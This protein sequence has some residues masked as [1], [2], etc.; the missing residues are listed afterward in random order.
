MLDCAAICL[1]DD[2]YYLRY[3][4]EALSGVPAHVFV[5]RLNWLGESSKSW[6]PSMKAA[7]S[8]GAI[9]HIGD[10]ATEH[11]HRLAALDLLRGLGHSN[12]LILD[13]DEILA[14][15]LLSALANLASVDAAEI[16]R[17]HMDTYWRSPSHVIRPRERLAP[18]VMINPQ[19]VD[20][21][22]VREFG[23]RRDEPPSTC[24]EIVL[25]P[26]HGVLHH[27]SYCGPDERILK[28]LSTWSHRNE[29]V[30]EWVERV[31]FQWPKDRLMRNLHPTHPGA[32]GW[33]EHINRPAILAD[34]P[35]YSGLP[36]ASALT[37]EESRWPKVSIVIPVYGA[38]HDLFACL[39][40]LAK[41]MDLIHEVILVDDAS[42]EPLEQY[43]QA[44]ERLTILRNEQV[45]QGAGGLGYGGSCNRGLQQTTGDVVVFL[46]SDTVVPRP[47][48]FRLIE[49][50]RGDN[51]AAAGP[52][53]NR[54]S[55]HQPIDPTYTSLENL[56]LFAQDFANREGPDLDV[57]MLVGFCLAVKKSVLDEVGG[58]DEDF[59]PGMFEDNDLCY[60][61]RRSGRRL[62]VS[63]R[64]YVHHEGS[65]SISKLK[66]PMSKMLARNQVLYRGKWFF[67]LQ[68]GFA[69]HLSGD[70]SEL[71][72]FDAER[73]P[74]KIIAEAQALAAEA[75][76]SLCMIVRNEE[77]VLADCLKSAQPFFKQMI[78]VDTGS[79]DRTV[80]IAKEFG[81]EVHEIVWPDS[82]AAARNESLKHAKGKWIFWMDAD[83]TLVFGCG[84]ELLHLAMNAPE[85]IG[86]FV[87]P[88]QFVESDGGTRVDH[89][90]LFRNRPG[91]CFEGRIHEQNVRS[92][93]AAGGEITRCGAYVLHSGY[94]TTGAGQA[95]KRERDFHLLELELKDRPEHPFVHFNWG[96]TEHHVGN[97]E[98]AL[99]WLE[100]SISLAP[101][102]DS[103]VRKSFV[104]MGN[105][106]RALNKPE[107]ALETYMKGLEVVGEDPELRFQ[108]GSVLND[109]DRLEEARDQYLQMRDDIDGHFVSLDVSILTFKREH[110]LGGIYLRMGDYVSAKEW[111][112]RAL[113][114]GRIYEPS[115]EM[116][117]AAALENLDVGVARDTISLVLQISGPTELW[118][119]MHSE[120]YRAIGTE[121]DADN[122]L[123]RA[124]A[125]HPRAIGPRLIYARRLQRTGREGEAYP[126]FLELA[127]LGCAEASFYLGVTAMGQGQ[128]ALAARCL[129]EAHQLNPAHEQ[130]LTILNEVRAIL[131]EEL[132]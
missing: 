84:M 3:V 129:E 105:C 126:H 94:D 113:S 90:K 32:Y 89:V 117:V 75:D 88:V 66:E 20:H 79:T 96:M 109:L 58:F 97:H 36:A 82:F 57:D 62:V 26:E 48:L 21:Y 43:L 120:Y 51:V 38:F 60:R 7:K 104:L 61:I 69:S 78:I 101:P 83:D 68:C 130:T 24:R 67:D 29:V 92:I 102:G 93:R 55:Y 115:A 23:P 98:K 119:K 16:V 49:S 8:L 80:E 99:E 53:T 128:H 95:R 100:T 108:A 74:D 22:S 35:D 131:G 59:Y 10:W 25:G 103:H 127:A 71:I 17:V 27:L 116:L 91:A 18:V 13:S 42:P 6:R 37:V 41:C 30:D 73:H 33:I 76:I 64:S 81:A 72:K 85:E 4:V 112:L 106:Y 86:G 77:R 52:Y 110:N 125:E 31:W 14:P 47:G 132:P 9:V 56:D 1:H 50:L 46:N 121:Q 34:V 28:K 124:I 114:H 70:R 65:K 87:V 12:V 123:L 19:R 122:F 15:E 45:K 40:S 63:H 118:A 5:S 44:G 107:Q 54:A 11:K 111:L 2:H 39:E